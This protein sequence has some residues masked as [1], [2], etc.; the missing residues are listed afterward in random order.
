MAAEIQTPVCEATGLPLPIRLTEPPQGAQ[1]HFEDY[2]HHFHPRM[3]PG[4]QHIDGK[5]VRFSRG[6]LVPRYLHDSYHKIFIGPE[7]PVSREDKFR[8]T[9]LA[10][11]GIVPRQAIDLSEPGSYTVVNLEDEEYER[12]ASPRSIYIE[13]AFKRDAGMYRRRSIGKFFAAFALEQDL[14]LVISDNVIGQFL[15]KKTSPE[16][17]KTLGNFML[18]EALELSIVDLSREHRILADDGLV[19]PVRRRNPLEVVRKYF[20]KDRY[21]DYHNELAIRIGALLV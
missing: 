4:L 7:L 19:L 2:H 11:A 18:K 16:Q 1:F 13:R 12:L 10:C 15:D 8:A 17:K 21:P 5:A 3:D 14:R 20:T 6:Q 9:V